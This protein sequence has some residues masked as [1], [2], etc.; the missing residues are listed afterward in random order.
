MRQMAET[1]AATE[2]QP[3]EPDVTTERKLAGA[4]DSHPDPDGTTAREC[5]WKPTARDDEKHV[6]NGFAKEARESPSVT[7]NGEESK[8]ERLVGNGEEE[9]SDGEGESGSPSED[10][11]GES[12]SVNSTGMEEENGNQECAPHWNQNGFAADGGMGRTA[13]GGCHVV[14]VTGPVEEVETEQVM[15]KRMLDSGLNC[16]AAAFQ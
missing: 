3:D 11:N 1:S 16:L 14:L 8:S 15:E 5:R 10:E 13:A 7:E 12:E 6:G 2:K 9:K 4:T